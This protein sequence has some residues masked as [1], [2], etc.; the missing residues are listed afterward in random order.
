MCLQAV[1]C[2]GK[3]AEERAADECDSSQSIKQMQRSGQLTSRTMA[4]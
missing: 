2:S 3:Y 1:W 4:T